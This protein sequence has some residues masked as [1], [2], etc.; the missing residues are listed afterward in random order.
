MVG[1]LVASALFLSLLVDRPG[2]E[3]TSTLLLLTVVGVNLF[4]FKKRPFATSKANWSLFSIGE[5]TPLFGLSVAFKT[6]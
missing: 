5:T 2:R 1:S 6:G 4:C 3:P